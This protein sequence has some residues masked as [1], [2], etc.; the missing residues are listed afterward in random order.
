MAWPV[1]DI[2]VVVASGCVLGVVRGHDPRVSAAA[3]GGGCGHQL[4]LS[5][6]L[7]P[8]V[9]IDDDFC[10]A[11]DGCA[12]GLAMALPYAHQRVIATL[13]QLFLYR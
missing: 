12:W 5:R 3:S 7:R 9:A 6:C 4:C 10:A 1:A 11:I 13:P 8:A 2:I